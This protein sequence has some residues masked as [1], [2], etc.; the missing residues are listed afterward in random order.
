[1][2][3]PHNIQV[4]QK[5][6]SRDGY[7][8]TVTKIGRVYAACEGS[9]RVPRVNLANLMGDNDSNWFTSIEARDAWKHAEEL[10]WKVRKRWETFCFEVKHYAVPQG[11][12]LECLDTLE[13]MVFGG[14]L[15]K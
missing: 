5:L 14:K 10:K 11:M 2:S 6:V 4:G 7:W 9:Y 8:I 13:V 12:T 3:N 1:M 15:N